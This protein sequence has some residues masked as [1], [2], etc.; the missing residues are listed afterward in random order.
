[1]GG[2]AV[3]VDFTRSW[4]WWGL[5]FR[6]ERRERVRMRR[7]KMMMIVEMRRTVRMTEI[8]KMMTIV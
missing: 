1:M 6:S 4:V 3:R 7:V 8:V 5:R 2:R